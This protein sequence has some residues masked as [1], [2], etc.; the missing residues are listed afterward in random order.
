MKY[1]ENDVIEKTKNV[2]WHKI[3]GIL[4]I[5]IKMKGILNYEKNEVEEIFGYWYL[6]DNN[7]YYV[8]KPII[9]LEFMH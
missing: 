3:I 6:I 4:T 2:L 8:E 1:V 7:V 9:I 5:C